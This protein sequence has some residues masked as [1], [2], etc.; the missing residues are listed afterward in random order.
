M[1]EFTD[2]EGPEEEAQTA[3]TG[4]PISET[5]RRAHRR[6]R[7]PIAANGR[8]QE[9]KRSAAIGPCA[10]SAEMA[11]STA[12]RK[13]TGRRPG[14][15]RSDGESPRSGR[16]GNRDGYSTGMVDGELDERTDPRRIVRRRPAI[17]DGVGSS[18]GPQGGSRPWEFEVRRVSLWRRIWR[19]IWRFGRKS[20]T[21][22][23]VRGRRGNS[24][25][26]GGRPQGHGR[27][28]R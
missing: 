25:G 7:N 28:G 3:P 18:M 6:R 27:G 9:T 5:Q 23:P 10:V 21:P 11:E 19:W 13:S 14:R 2:M 8:A 22:N 4:V 15:E 12:E 1:P 26:R 20:P 24:R 16:G 17:R